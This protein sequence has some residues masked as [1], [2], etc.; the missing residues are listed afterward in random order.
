MGLNQWK[1]GLNTYVS[2]KEVLIVE[3]RIKRYLFEK[4]W[5]TFAAAFAKVTPL[6]CITITG[7]PVRKLNNESPT[8][9][10]CVDTSLQMLRILCQVITDE[11][12]ALKASKV[13]D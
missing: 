7:L 8:Y 2:N 12:K 3:K 13:Q 5:G 6:T 9:K 11:G 1:S 10:L 4:G